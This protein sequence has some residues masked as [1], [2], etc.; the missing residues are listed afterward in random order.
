MLLLLLVAAHCARAFDLLHVKIEWNSKHKT[1]L[2][3]NYISFAYPAAAAVVVPSGRARQNYNYSRLRL[4]AMMVSV[5]VNHI[6]ISIYSAVIIRA[7]I[8]VFARVRL[9]AIVFTANL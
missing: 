8:T 9:E 3:V 6:N 7:V 4:V 5:T 2:A 1:L